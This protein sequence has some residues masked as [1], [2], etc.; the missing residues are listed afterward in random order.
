MVVYKS[1]TDE[2]GINQVYVYDGLKGFVYEDVN[3]PVTG[4]KVYSG[5]VAGSISVASLQGDAA[6]SGEKIK[7]SDPAF[8]NF[9]NDWANSG[10]V[11]DPAPGNNAS[12]EDPYGAWDID[13]VNSNFTPGST[14]LTLEAGSWQDLI[15]ID[16]ITLKIPTGGLVVTKKQPHL[17]LIL[18]KM[19]PTK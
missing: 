15:L 10:G 3:I 5:D 19:V 1:P 9:P 7:V 13:V 4:Y 2:T 18:A 8:S 16:L 12:T 11:S 17:M 14:S 6:I